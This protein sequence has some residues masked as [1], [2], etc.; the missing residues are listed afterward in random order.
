MTKIRTSKTKRLNEILSIVKLFSLL[1]S[2]VGL[3]VSI[4]ARGG[5]NLS[6][7]ITPVTF[8][9]I[10]ALIYII[11]SN[12]SVRNFNE[13]KINTIWMVE[14]YFFILVFA[15][16]IYYSGAYE[17]K[18]KYLF[19][20]IIITSTIQQ[21]MKFGIITAVISSIAIL[22]MDLVTAS[23]LAVN[24][25]FEADLVLAAL[26]I[27]MAWLVGH[28]ANIEKEYFERMENLAHTDELTGL[29]NHRYFYDSLREHIRHNKKS[30]PLSMIFMDI[31]SF[32]Y[33]NDLFGHQKGDNV[34]IEISKILLKNV[35]EGDIVARYAGDE[36]A[37]LMPDIEEEQALVTAE[38]IRDQIESTH[39]DGQENMPDHNLTVS[40]GVSVY[41]HKADSERALVKSAD[42][43]LYRAK[44]FNKN[45]VEI[46][47]STLDMLKD[48][49]EEEHIDLVTS[50]KTL[51]TIINSKDRYTYGHV[52]RVVIYSKLF[53]EHLGLSN[54]DKNTLIYGAYM[55]DLG[56][57]NIPEEVLNKQ[58]PLTDEEWALIEA[59][60]E[61]GV[62]IVEP[63][64]TLQDTIPIIMHHHER[65]DGTGYPSNLKGENIPYLARVLTVIDAFDAMTFK[66]SYSDKKSFDEAIEE[67]KRCSGTQFDPALAEE[68]IKVVKKNKD[69]IAK[70]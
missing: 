33:Y 5:E 27:V 14:N 55:H 21:G 57:I 6:N 35:S 68:F 32:K 38:R 26:F 51:I 47:T 4:Y 31:D 37:I 40:V 59:H 41:P 19:L 28:Y 43:A 24:T 67:L 63:V 62:K 17:S 44:F 25:Y 56:K 20:F 42:D 52:E 58:M 61:N 1:F 70:L 46:Y 13:R 30:K 2:G 29:S 48:D 50:M 9:V 22:G 45:R 53:A 16:V 10:L 23:F 18:N 3:Y 69:Q 7:I 12:V 34:L 66:R 11:W 36:F 64:N 39:F 54:A 8:M 15:F 49:I 65:Y 60:P